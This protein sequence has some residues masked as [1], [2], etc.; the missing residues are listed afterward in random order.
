MEAARRAEKISAETGSYVDA[1]LMRQTENALHTAQYHFRRRVGDAN[2]RQPAPNAK[3]EP[4][5]GGASS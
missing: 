1:L 3:D 5:R 2:E 4:R